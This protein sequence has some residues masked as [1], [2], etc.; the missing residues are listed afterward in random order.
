MA[1]EDRQFVVLFGR[2]RSTRALEVGAILIIQLASAVPTFVLHSVTVPPAT[3][4]ALHTAS[5]FSGGYDL[6]VSSTVNSVP[7]P[8]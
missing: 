2:R 6:K 3:R 1:L 4:S 5:V 8:S 7:A